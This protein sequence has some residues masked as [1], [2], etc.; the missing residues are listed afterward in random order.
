MT[1]F[2]VKKNF[3]NLPSEFDKMLK[4]KTLNFIVSSGA[5]FLTCENI[6]LKELI[7]YSIKLYKAKKIEIIDNYLP[8]RKQLKATL[9]T[10]TT[11]E[12]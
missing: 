3:I 7:N 6:Y 5:A 8:S 12:K 10:E 9:T 1:E 2:L 4:E 11:K